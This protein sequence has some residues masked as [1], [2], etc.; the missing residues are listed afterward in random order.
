MLFRRPGQRNPVQHFSDD[1]MGLSRSQILPQQ[2]V[3][4]PHPKHG[5][6]IA[7]RFNLDHDPLNHR[8]ACCHF[9]GRNSTPGAS[10]SEILPGEGF[11]GTRRQPD[12][13]NNIVIGGKVQRG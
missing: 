12:R 2:Q 7:R 8:P 5:P 1:E 4:H 13:K 9:S 11:E 10:A 3:I 6:G